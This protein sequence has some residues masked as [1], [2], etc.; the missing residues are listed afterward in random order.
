MNVGSFRL[1]SAEFFLKP[2]RVRLQSCGA[3]QPSDLLDTNSA[4]D[5]LPGQYVG[6]C[7]GRILISI[8]LFSSASE[9]SKT[10]QEIWTGATVRGTPIYLCWWIIPALAVENQR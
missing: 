10:S 8:S 2:V 7:Q 5:S 3:F 9:Y 1:F 4:I 6:F